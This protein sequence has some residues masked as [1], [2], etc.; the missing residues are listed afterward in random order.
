MYQI[1]Y[2]YTVAKQMPCCCTYAEITGTEESGL[3]KLPNSFGSVV[4]ILS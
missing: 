1:L 4:S 3:K 2:S